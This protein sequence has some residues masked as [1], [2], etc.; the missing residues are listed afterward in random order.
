MKKSRQNKSSSVSNSRWLAYAA[1][2]AATTLAGAHSAELRF[3]I[4]A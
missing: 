4:R 3:T 2:G 1:A